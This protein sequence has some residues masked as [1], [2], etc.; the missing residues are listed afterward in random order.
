MNK[1][2]KDVM[3][4]D[5]IKNQK[6]VQEMNLWLQ[7]RNTGGEGPQKKIWIQEMCRRIKI[8]RSTMKNMR[9]LLGNKNL[10]SP[11]VSLVKQRRVSWDGAAPVHLQNLQEQ[12]R[13]C[14]NAVIRKAW[15]T[16]HLQTVD[17]DENTYIIMARIPTKHENT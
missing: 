11:A 6:Q 8:E 7:V 16:R 17:E 5:R 10:P 14:K 1:N 13:T 12:A 3:S 4:G 15:L 9:I 2:Q